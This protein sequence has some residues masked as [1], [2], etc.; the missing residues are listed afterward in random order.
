MERGYIEL[1]DW[2]GR[3][4]RDDKRGYI[5]EHI[6]PIIHRLGIDPAGYLRHVSGHSTGAANVFLGAVERVRAV[7]NRFGRRFA[8]GQRQGQALYAGVVG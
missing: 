8:R 3:I 7:A 6:P 4:V 5:G 2:A 1:V